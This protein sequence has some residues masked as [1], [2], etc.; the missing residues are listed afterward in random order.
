MTNYL[1]VV[2]RGNTEL[3]DL[4]SVAFRGHT[5]FQV[6]IDRRGADSRAVPVSGP[7]DAAGERRGGRVMLG[8]DEIIVAERADRADRPVT[9]GG[10]LRTFQHVP[11]RRRRAR[12]SA[13]RTTGASPSSHSA[14][15]PGGRPAT[16]C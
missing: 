11:V 5:G 7:G 4:L 1:I 6:V 9:G 13:S 12:P 15:G 8:H 16:A 10:T 3:F 14:A 2:P